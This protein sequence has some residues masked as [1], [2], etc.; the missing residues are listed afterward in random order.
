MSTGDEG[1][2]VQDNVSGGLLRLDRTGF[3][4]SLVEDTSKTRLL[5]PEADFNAKNERCQISHCQIGGE[6]KWDITH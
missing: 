1:V 5:V 6:P 3:P 2:S 4:E